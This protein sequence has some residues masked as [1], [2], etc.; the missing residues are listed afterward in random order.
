MPWVRTSATAAIATP[1]RTAR[2][3]GAGESMSIVTRSAQTRSGMRRAR[4]SG[5]DMIALLSTKLT[6]RRRAGERR[7]CGERSRQAECSP[8]QLA[9]ERADSREQHRISKLEQR[10][11]SGEAW[12][13]PPEKREERRVARL[14]VRRE[15]R[16]RQVDETIALAGRERLGEDE[17]LRRH[18]RRR[19][20][21]ARSRASPRAARERRS[22]MVAIA[23]RAASSRA[24]GSARRGGTAVA[25]DGA[26]TLEWS[27]VTE[28][29]SPETS[30]QRTRQRFASLE[31]STRVALHCSEQLKPSWSFAADR[32]HVKQ[33]AK[34][35]RARRPFPPGLFCF[36][37]LQRRA[38][39]APE[40]VDDASRETASPSA[41]RR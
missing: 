29:D 36:V 21:A 6:D 8:C 18:R 25:T 33:G 34:K 35:R 28:A 31:R 16:A 19:S 23:R 32:R 5:S 24:A 39:R 40:H 7:R 15:R 1:S 22:A 14:E 38:S 12:R 37:S 4:K 41:P 26:D 30:R 17:I 27:A 9:G 2:R 20:A 10:D 11:V 3:N 13:D